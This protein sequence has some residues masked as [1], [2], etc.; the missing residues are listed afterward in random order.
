[1]HGAAITPIDTEMRGIEIIAETPGSAKYN[2]AAVPM[3]ASAVRGRPIRH[4]PLSLD[5]GAALRL[6]I[7]T[8]EE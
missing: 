5:F 7:P 4:E 3:A 8:R 6:T 2:L 1:M